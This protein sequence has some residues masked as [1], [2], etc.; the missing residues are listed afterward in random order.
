[1]GDDLDAA[2]RSGLARPDRCAKPIEIY[3]ARVKEMSVTAEA[4]EIRPARL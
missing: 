3:T 4:A 1:L 2:P